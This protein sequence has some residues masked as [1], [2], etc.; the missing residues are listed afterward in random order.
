MK[1]YHE[2]WKI[3]CRTCNEEIPKEFIESDDEELAAN[4]AKTIGAILRRKSK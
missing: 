1:C 4:I 2:K 3:V